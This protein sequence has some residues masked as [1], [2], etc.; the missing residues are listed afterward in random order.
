MFS[1]SAREGFLLRA[2]RKLELVGCMKEICPEST[3]AFLL[4]TG[5]L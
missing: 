4:C 2:Y 3:E 1:R 5:D